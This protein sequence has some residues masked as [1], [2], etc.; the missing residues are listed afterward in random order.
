MPLM[1]EFA[2][3]PEDQTANLETVSKEKPEGTT[4]P[5][6]TVPLDPN[7]TEVLTPEALK[8][9]EE[10]RQ[11]PP[12][13]VDLPEH[14]E[15]QDRKDPLGPNSMA[16]DLAE[17]QAKAPEKPQYL[18]DKNTEAADMAEKN[19]PIGAAAM[20]GE[21][22]IVTAAG[23][24]RGEDET[25]LEQ[26]PDP[27][28]GSVLTEGSPEAG[29]P[30]KP[31]DGLREDDRREDL[32][33]AMP[34]KA[35]ETEKDPALSPVKPAGRP[36][37]PT[38]APQDVGKA[39]PNKPVPG[40]RSDGSDGRPD[41][42]AETGGGE[43]PLPKR[44]EE[45]VTAGPQGGAEEKL[46][47]PVPIM[48]REDEKLSANDARERKVPS[49]EDSGRPDVPKDPERGRV[50]DILKGLTRAAPDSDLKDPGIAARKGQ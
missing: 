49:P 40:E 7:R 41:G 2:F 34:P 24:R 4:V 10:K 6:E 8:A 45:H 1:V 14:E 46:P 38:T 37:E 36:D 28:T 30:K 18:G 48:S 5:A 31:L 47:D 23:G 25:K 21:S 22:K 32:A 12:A 43:D 3:P 39:E 33:G 17:G 44:G 15:P 11:T 19:K 29:K 50:E 9:P 35:P 13:K 42:F 16:Y 20:E 26:V 27:N